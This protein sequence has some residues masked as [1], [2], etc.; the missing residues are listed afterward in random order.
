M[1]SVS[2]V[3]WIDYLRGFITVLV[4]A[5]HSSLAYTTF[6][7]FNSQAYILSTHPVVDSVRSR[8]LDIFE[9]FNDVFFMSLMFLISG[10]FVL[11]GLVRKGRQVFIRD[12]FYRL[13]I[14]FMIGVTALMLVA[15]FPAYYL[16]HHSL[17]LRAYI[18]DF[19]TVEGWPVGPPWF[20]WVLFLFNLVIALTIPLT[21]RLLTN[22]GKTLGGLARSPVKLLLCWF[23]ITWCLYIPFM[24]WAGP[25][26]WTGIGPF[27]FQISR[28]ILYFGYFILGISIGSAGPDAGLFAEGPTPEKLSSTANLSSPAKLSSR[29][30]LSFSTEQ[31]SPAKTSPFAK[32]WPLWTTLCLLAYALLKYSETFL[33]GLVNQHTLTEYQANLIYRSIWVLSCTAS[34]I[35]FLALFQRLFTHPKKIWDELSANAYGIYLFHY[36]FVVWCQFLLLNLALPAPVKFLITFILSLLLSWWLVSRIRKNK[37]IAKYL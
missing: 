25:Y 30:G 35:A 2:R 24:L 18:I 33:P 3:P 7:S 4:V 17:D 19:F 23:I 14:P 36:I 12:R 28:F 37:L 22:L 21:Q 20:I 8:S 9:D 16:A 27:D 1:K 13:F 34:S 6:A 31:S 15:Y 26:A 32:K 29:P 10:I 11:P 5:H